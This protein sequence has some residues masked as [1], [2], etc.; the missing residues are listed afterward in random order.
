V[1]QESGSGF[2]N[3]TLFKFAFQA[4]DTRYRRHEQQQYGNSLIDLFQ[5]IK[6]PLMRSIKYD[7]PNT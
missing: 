4:L 2:V 7:K 5:G 6:N 3:H 1:R